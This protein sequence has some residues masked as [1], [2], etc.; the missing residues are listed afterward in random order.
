MGVAT[1]VAIAGVA[2]SAYSASRSRSAGRDA[3]RQQQSAM[4][5]QAQAAQDQLDFSR[6][7]YDDW[8]TMFRPVA[9]DLKTMAYENRGP[10]YNAINAD[11]GAAFDTSQAINRRQQQR[12]GFQPSDGAVQNSELQYGLGRATA[13]VNARN[14]A[15]T[16]NQD[17]QFNRL[18]AFYGMGS[19]QGQAAANLVSAA[20]AGVGN[21]YGQHAGI[22]GNQAMNYGNQANQSMNDA[23]GWAGWG[24]GQ[25]MQGRNSVS[26]MDPIPISPVTR[27]NP[28]IGG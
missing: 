24:F 1:A 17:K 27:Q 15:R 22:Y 5:Q 13:M 4:D 6:E 3:A 11:V 14:Q 26:G 25:Y 28:P 19:G 7:Q 12:F 2:T 9:E 8:R 20:H 10:D 21:A 18:T 23:M 16:A